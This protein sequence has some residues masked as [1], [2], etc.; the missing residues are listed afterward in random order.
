MSNN[1]AF[2]AKTINDLMED[3]LKPVID[4]VRAEAIQEGMKPEEI[5]AAISGAKADTQAQMLPKLKK[6]LLEKIRE[7]NKKEKAVSSK[8]GSTNLAPGK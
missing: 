7:E 8:I 3:M 4:E 1:R 6:L 2:F 5:E